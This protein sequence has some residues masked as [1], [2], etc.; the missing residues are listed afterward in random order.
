MD[1]SCRQIADKED[2]SD[3]DFDCIK[4]DAELKHI[5]LYRKEMEAKAQSVLKY[6]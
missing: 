4:I 2:L 3:P 5:S 1:I 6:P